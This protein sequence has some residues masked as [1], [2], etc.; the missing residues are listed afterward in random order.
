MDCIGAC[1][2]LLRLKAE[3]VLFWLWIGIGISVG[4][5]AVEDVRGEVGSGEETE[6]AVFVSIGLLRGE[7]PL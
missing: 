3:A 6:R 2:S 4:N 5:M 1:M 7:A